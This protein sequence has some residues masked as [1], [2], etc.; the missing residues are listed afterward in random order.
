MINIHKSFLSTRTYI[1][2]NLKRN[3]GNERKG[4][5]NCIWSVHTKIFIYSWQTITN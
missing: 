5:S 2:L 3:Q 1:F 4:K